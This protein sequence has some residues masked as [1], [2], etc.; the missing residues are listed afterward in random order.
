MQPSLTSQ[1]RAVVDR[2]CSLNVPQQSNGPRPA[3]SRSFV[4]VRGAVTG[5]GAGQQSPNQPGRF[6][7][8]M[9]CFSLCVV[10][11]RKAAVI[12]STA[13]ASTPLMKA[14]RFYESTLG[15]KAVMAVTGLIL[16]GFLVVHM[17][18]NLQ[19][20]LGREVMNHYAETLHANPAL[21]WT[22]RTVLL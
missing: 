21:L 20:F 2:A 5:F 3:S 13:I 7:A 15:K 10:S 17:L 19:I 22:A 1:L 9:V 8:K 11:D 16:F 12:M 14:A 4:S 18:G 6:H